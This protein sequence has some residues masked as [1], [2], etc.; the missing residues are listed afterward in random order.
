MS[1]RHYNNTAYQEFQQTGGRRNGPQHE[2]GGFAAQA[3]QRSGMTQRE[4]VLKFE[5][6]RIR[7]LQEERLHI[8]K[9][10]FTKWMNS[11]LQKARM[12]VEDLFVDLADGRKLLKLL[13]IISGE[14]LAKPNNGRMR[15]HKI[16]N[17]NKSLAFLHT[18]VRLESIGAEDIVDGNPRLILG[19]IWTIILRFQIQEIEIDVDEEN[20]SSEK[21][22]AKDALL[23]WCQ[24]KTN[25][26]QGVHITNFTDSWRTGLGFSALIHSHR[27]DLFDYS[28]LPAQSNMDNLNHAFNT[29]EDQLGIPKLL[30]AEDVDTSRPD[31]KSVITYVASYYHTFARMKNE[32]KIGRRI[33]NIVGQLMD[34]DAKKNQYSR[35]VTTLLEWIRLK[36]EELADRDFPNSLDGIQKLLL[37]FKQYRTVEKPPKYK[38][39]SEIEA[40]FFHINLVAK[41][42]GREAFVPTAGQQPA[43]LERAWRR[44]EAAEHTREVALRQE[45]LRQQR[46]EH[47]NY[48]F[49]TKAVLRRGYLKEMIQVLSDPRYGS[50]LSQVDATVKKHE[51]ISADILARTERFDDLTAMAEEL[52]RE[53]YHGAEAVK[54][55]ERA[56]LAGWSELL[57]LLRGHQEALGRLSA[58]MALMREVDATLAS[59]AHLRSQLVS[60]DVGPHLVGVE[61]QSQRLALQELQLGALGETSRRLARQGAALSVPAQPHTLLKQRQEQLQADYDDLVAAAKERKARLEDARNLYQFLEDH[62][63]EES[64]VT[65]RQRICRAA[66]TAKDLRAVLSLQ[67]KHTALRHEMRARERHTAKVTSKGNSLVEEQHPKSVEISRRLESLARLW[68][69][70]RELA[71]LRDKQLREAAEAYQF[72][73]DANEADSWLKDKLSLAGSSDLGSD[74]PSAQALLSRHRALSG[75]LQ[76]YRTELATLNAQADRLLKQGI[77]CLQLASENDTAASEADG[78][79]PTEEWVNETRLVPTEVWEEE[80]VE[81]LEHRTVTEERS[82]PQVKALYA[83]NGQGMTMAKGEVMFLINKTNPDWWSVRK[84]DGTDGFVPANYVKEIEPRIVPV[85]VRRPEK[86]RSVQRVKKTVLTKQ[87]VR[88]R[89]PPA[90]RSRSKAARPAPRAQPEQG[91]SVDTRRQKINTSY[92]RLVQ[93]A[94]ERHAALE[95]AIRLYGFYGDCDDLERWIKDKEKLLKADDPADSVDT[96]KRKYEKFVTDL[97]ASR[98]R[99]ARV[100]AGVEELAS[101]KHPQL[102]RATQRAN[103]I[104]RLWDNL[105]RLKE[106]KEKSLEGA[107]T[108]ELFERTC[109]EAVEWMS[110]KSLQLEG[111]ELGADLHTVRAL[112]RR[113]AQLERELAPLRDRVA[114]VHML[115]DSVKSAYPAERA[116]V[117]RRQREVQAMWEECEKKA[118]ERRE[119]LES[120]VGHQIFIRSSA[121]LLSWLQVVKEQLAAEI[122]AKDVA[123]AENLGKQHNE[124]L[125]DINAH[126]D[127]LNEVIGLGEKLVK[128]NPALTEV[129]EKVTL[130]KADRKAVDED[131]KKKQALLAQCL[132]LQSFNREADRIDASSGAHEAFLEFQDLG[133]SVESVEALVKRHE[134]F[135]SSLAAQDDRLRAFYQQADGL[136]KTE[137]YATPQILQRKEAVRARREA[138]RMAAAERRRALQASLA[139]HH[140]SAEADDLDAFIQDKMRTATDQSY[141]DLT[142]L[143]RKLQKHE[144]FERELHANEG[145]LRNVTNT[146]EA[147]IASEPARSDAVN[148]RLSSLRSRWAGLR[149]AA[150]DRARALRQAAAQ[151]AHARSAQDARERLGELRRDLENK[152]TGRD[153]RTCK[154]LLNKHQALE[155]E[156]SQWEQRVGELQASGQDLAA[157]GHFDVDSVQ[158]ESKLAAGALTDLQEPAQRR[159]TLLEEGLKFHKFKFSL[160]AELQWV[161]ERAAAASSSLLGTDLHAAQGLHKKHAKLLQ[162]L[163]AH[164]PGVE[165]EL[166]RGAELVAQKLP[167]ADK[168]EE[169]C[170][171]L[172][173]AWTAIEAAGLARMARLERSLRVQQFLHDA[174]DVESWL[175]DRGAALASAEKG[176][177]RD[178]AMQLLTAHK[179]MELEL[180]TYSA[181]IS[182]MGHSATAMVAGGQDAAPLLERTAQLAHSLAALQKLAALR[183]KALVESMCRHEYLSESSEL[184]EWIQEQLAAAS[185]EDYGQDYEHLLILRSKFEELR[186]RVEAG[187]ERFNQCE[188]LARK[189]VTPDSPYIG[190]I[191]RKQEQLGE[192]WQKLVDQMGARAQR[193]GAAGDIHRFHRDAAEALGRV[194]DKRAMLPDEDAPPRDLNHALALLRRHEGLENDMLALEAQLQVLSEDAAR[195]QQLYPGGNASHIGLQ[196]T[197]LAD[198]WERLRQAA[199]DH[200]DRL[201]AACDLHR[202][203]AQVRDLT[204]WSSGLRAAMAAPVKARDVSAAAALKAEHEAAKAEIEAREDSFRTALDMGRAMVQT[205]HRS[206]QEV[207]ERMAALLEEHQRLIAAWQARQVALDQLIDLQFFLRDAKQ[208]LNLCHAHEAALG[209]SPDVSSPGSVE[210]VDAQLKKHEA[211][212][213]LLNTQEEKVIALNT[214]GDK[215]LQQH[216]PD[217]PLISE[218]LQKVNQQRKKVRE[219]CAVRRDSLADALLHAQFTRDVAETQFWI[220]DKSKKLE[221]DQGG[222]VT[223]LEDKI[224]KLQKHQAFKAEL[225]ANAGRV[226]E[227]KQ[228]ASLLVERRHGAAS[229]VQAAHSKLEDAWKDL[230]DRADQRG[231]GLEEAQDMLEFNNQVDKIEAWIRDKEMMVNAADT[232]RDYEHCSALLRKLDDLDSDMRVDDKHIKSISALAD[233]LLQQGPTSGPA[234]AQRR[235][236]F[237]NKWRALSGALQEYRDNLAAALEIHQYNRDVQETME[238]TAEKAALL[239]G[240]EKAKDLRGVERLQRRRDALHRDSSALHAKI[241]AHAKESKRLATKYPSKEKAIKEK[242]GELQDAWVNLQQLL[243][244]RRQQLDDA[245]TVQK[246]DA[247][248]KE[249][250]VWVG[251][252]VK[253]LE[254]S[255]PPASVADAEA[256][257]ELHQERKAE[258]D[259]RQKSIQALS[260][261]ALQLPLPEGE[262]KEKRP[263]RLA[264]LSTELHGAWDQR[265]D[266]LTQAHQ[267]QLFKEQARQTED[268]LAAKEAFLN[269]DDLGDSLPAVE[270]LIRKHAEFDK[271]VRAQ[272]AKVE[273]L[274]K[275]AEELLGYGHFDRKYIERRLANVAGRLHKLKEMSETRA[276]TLQQSRQLQQFLRDLYHEHEWLA[277]KAQLAND[278]SYK[279]L[280]NLQS[281]IQRHAAFESELNANQ[282]R[283]HAVVRN[284]EELIKSKHYASTE[285]GSHVDGL[286]SEWRSLQET[287]AGRR[288]RLAAA[289]QARVFLRGLDDFAAWAEDVEAQ[290]QSTDHGKDLASVA[291]LLARHSRLEQEVAQRGEETAQLRETAQHLTAAKHFMAQEI[292]QRVDDA[293]ARYRQLQE[294]MSIRRDN[295]EEAQQLQRW[296]RDAGEELRWLAERAPLLGPTA[297]VSAVSLTQAQSLQKK[298]TALEAELLSREPIVG[299]LASRSAQMQLRG[300]FAG[301]RLE[302]QAQELQEALRSL[303]DQAAVRRVKLQDAVDTHMFLAEAAEAEAWLAERR[304]LLESTE[305][306]RDEDSV[307][308]LQRRLEAIQREIATFDKQ[309]GRLEQLGAALVARQA[310]DGAGAEARAAG[311]RRA[312]DEL[313]LLG[314]RRQQR[315]QESDKYF[316]FLRE[317]EEVHEWIH[318]Q[319]AVAASEDYGTDVEHVE[320]LIQAFDNFV[321]GFSA[322]EGRVE[323]IAEAGQRLVEE[324]SPET[325]KIQRHIAD[326]RALWEDLRDLAHA[327]QEALAGARQVH[328]F[329][330]T[331]DETIQWIAEKESALSTELG[332]GHDLHAIQ[333]LVKKHDAMEADLEAVKSQVD[334]L[335]SEAERLGSAFPDAKEH[336]SVKLEEVAEALGGLL[337][338]AA[339]GRQH[340]KQAG[341]LQALFDEYGELMAWTSEMLA[342]VTAPELAADVA[343]A[344]QL[345]ARH[346]EIRTEIDARQEDFTNF[347]KT[348]AEL[349][350]SEHFLAEELG[351]K[352]A[353]LR[354][355]AQL[356]QDTWSRRTTIYE[357][358]LDTLLFKRDADTLDNWILNREPQLRDGKLGENITQAEELIKKHEDFQKTVEAQ[359]ERFNALR[360]ITLVEQAFGELRNREAA[361]RQEEKERQERERAEG[362]RAAERARIEQQRRLEQDRHATKVEP[363]PGT[364]DRQTPSTPTPIINQAQQQHSQQPSPIAP[365]LSATDHSSPQP[366]QVQKSA[367]AAQAFGDRFKRVTTGVKRAES[368]KDVVGKTPKRTPSFTTRRRS[369][370]FRKLQRGDPSDLPPVEIE[371]YLERKHEAG[372]GGQ[373]AAVRSWRGY[374]TVLCGQLLCFFRDEMDFSQAKAA[375]PPVSILKAEC[376]RASDYTKRKH[377]FRLR[378]ADGAEFLFACTTA[379]ALQDWVAKL[380]FHA[381]LPPSLQL[382]SYGENE[383]L[384]QKLHHN[385]SSSSSPAS[386]PEPRPRQRT[387]AEILQQHRASRQSNA[388][389][390]GP[391]TP[392]APPRSSTIPDT[393]PKAESHGPAIPPRLQS[394]SPV[395]QADI[396]IRRQTESSIGNGS[397]PMS[398]STVTA[399]TGSSGPTGSTGSTGSWGKSRYGGSN[400]DINTD[401]INSQAQ[402]ARPPPLPAS[403][404]PRRPTD[405]HHHGAN[406]GHQA[407]VQSSGGH[408]SNHPSNTHHLSGQ[409]SHLS[410]QASHLSGQTHLSGHTSH[411]S[412]QSSHL[413]GQTSHLSGQM[414]HLSGQMSHLSGQ[415]SHLSGQAS[416]EDWPRRASAQQLHYH[417]QEQRQSSNNN[418]GP[419]NNWQDGSTAHFY[420]ASDY[421]YQQNAGERAA[422]ESSGESELSIGGQPDKQKRGVFGLFKK[423]KPRPSSHNN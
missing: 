326:T 285:I 119:R 91:D 377:V 46:L 404:P 127:E 134:D 302:Q 66:I 316:G 95:D 249:L 93:M 257:L 173:A 220:Q 158:Q 315:L 365:N 69:Q 394:V 266:H 197:A 29:A 133:D 275:F 195:L 167:D 336:V 4:D 135:E 169:L 423:K 288:E 94:L 356:L 13:E 307:Q 309:C 276:Q 305:N 303:K 361:A 264:E 18:K 194:R 239:T 235:D 183:Q 368:M 406:P 342:R 68:E 32:Q 1:G 339:R 244:A 358:H 267:L 31:E 238:R 103:Q 337:G 229:D 215:L 389:S 227:L 15:V 23:L 51:A 6:G 417:H 118:A 125:D 401:F 384:R 48:K 123:T 8:Q 376:E 74:E 117:D 85:Q 340:L 204:S 262:D 59:I 335:T 416:H 373:R 255:E 185:S 136:V 114:R 277:L 113:H 126:R 71:D 383:A 200:R 55:S 218:E 289:Y 211:F 308:A 399:L 35:L 318:D 400:R 283:I 284:G 222:E 168:I 177:D 116:N 22:S 105:N 175:A 323:A 382:L 322:N 42:L 408:M 122:K 179:A 420:T 280:S 236:A 292:Q 21:K 187:E 247:D 83:F 278:Q 234:V 281:K 112:Q 131:W 299:G 242:L 161:S 104:Q 38:E 28:R 328:I 265:R 380:D 81:R 159:R 180:D 16:E 162:E 165:R 65:D 196:Q 130:L 2:P 110:E 145:Q 58:L 413:S 5:Q 398:D 64:W 228:K 386:S 62:E 310:E 338:R 87:V 334:R 390:D 201:N 137:H 78:A 208:L 381:G 348:G 311:V 346:Q 190:D 219:L 115:A 395:D 353:A 271:L 233:K 106:Q 43:E 357:Q 120:A 331:A 330:R 132:Q 344:E 245:H 418:V 124:L 72:Y 7:A 128:G 248:L 12:E 52:V 101:Q 11:F 329:D 209:G 212:E 352:I 75:E 411:L 39:R 325:E 298:H 121:S 34:A 57:A 210:E 274:K 296:A 314:A 53:K 97:S 363:Q 350:D 253:K 354:S 50:N 98:S 160:D 141:R 90:A 407:P 306:G 9:K 388:S 379:A 259:N 319:T 33:A 63:E 351:E 142:N 171:E 181:I 214:H 320:I 170:S 223:S 256:L 240:G 26:Y 294:P 153:L 291:A 19:L 304:P 45:L 24:R 254:S 96:A 76:S 191:E 224:K 25:G 286:E 172:R 143:E 367:S 198:N 324:R 250:E 295:L 86:V 61:E 156:M 321:A 391:V 3:Q 297:P 184:E 387:Q 345:L 82:V 263:Q 108:V 129:A 193:L 54:S 178:H 422:A 67:Q 375:A 80:P 164:K 109:A 341:Q 349:V 226:G 230:L 138:V 369:Q 385:G 49:N 151:R 252:T 371:G 347:Y 206:A 79:A 10:T 148:D 144:A 166:A 92:E 419:N 188:E 47:L 313:T 70:L 332:G 77:D 374:H 107:S 60:E 99:L 155:L 163:Q 333:A 231:R 327:R 44:L 213:R 405:H 202:F 27:P 140:F 415:T 392:P 241:D 409:M 147:L 30:D 372:S 246:L 260:S 152:E 111:A 216:H 359:Q 189:L 293:L 270:A 17:V 362:R 186:H 393:P 396:L 355:R 102:E 100:H 282:D 237:L 287:A 36:I 199:S 273:E 402:K 232:G 403:L 73:A 182:E 88:V 154:E 360:R 203:L 251:E 290:L 269:N 317:V 301:A 279:D 40:L 20:E 397:R 146:G 221:A 41:S 89:A 364:P 225:A 217:S 343:G 421:A 139:Y 56:V 84:A 414:S 412:G 174:L 150:A 268:W 300:H 410:G 378:C 370:S 192:S 205:G 243:E 258:I 207:E 272:E 261:E 312:L 149:G 37:A 176:R 366:S 157:E 14:K